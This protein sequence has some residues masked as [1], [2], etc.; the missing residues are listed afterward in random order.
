MG[1]G[2]DGLHE[3]IQGLS[4]TW[5]HQSRSLEMTALVCRPQPHHTEG[6]GEEE[7]RGDGVTVG[8]G[9]RGSGQVVWGEVTMRAVD[10]AGF[11]RRMRVEVRAKGGCPGQPRRVILA[12]PIPTTAFM[13]IDEA[14]QRHRYEIDPPPLEVGRSEEERGSVMS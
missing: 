13:D 6:E 2:G 12:Q 7:E 4:F 3:S 10:Q 11:H 14:Q 8:I 9:D 1:E 5:Q